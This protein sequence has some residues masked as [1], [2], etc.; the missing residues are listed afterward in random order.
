MGTITAH[1]GDDLI[2]SRTA[3]ETQREAVTCPRSHISQ[4]S[5]QVELRS[6]DTGWTP[7]LVQTAR[8]GVC[9]CMPTCVYVHGCGYTCIRVCAC[10]VRAYEELHMRISNILPSYFVRTSH[11]FSDSYPM[12]EVV[13][14]FLDLERMA[15]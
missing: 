14:R 1:F 12:A 8:W 6:P 3:A 5:I 7:A 10:A 13:S 9:P 11:T 4:Q 2:R 15:Y